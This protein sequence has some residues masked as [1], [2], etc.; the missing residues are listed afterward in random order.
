M[1]ESNF[2]TNQIPGM[3]ILE[4][5]VPRDSEVSWESTVQMLTNLRGNFSF[6]KY[7]RLFRRQVPSMSFEI[8]TINQSIKFFVILPTSLR[9]FFESQLVSQ[10]P[11][12]VSV[13]AE[14]YLTEWFSQSYVMSAELILGKPAYLPIRTMKDFD[15]TVDP[16]S[17]VLG[18]M[19]KILPNE[20]ILVQINLSGASSGWASAAKSL[21]NPPKVEGQTAVKP[22]NSG[23]IEEKIALPGFTSAIRLLVAAPTEPQAKALIDSVA[24][25]FGSYANGDGNS[26]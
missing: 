5:R 9:S 3:T 16:L 20:Q 25:S 18:V 13:E 8:A 7:A 14:N 6:D 15:A 17:S 2:R 21:L 23:I 10:Y 26:L 19:S 22:S 24:G 12:A 4:I 1:P 11:L